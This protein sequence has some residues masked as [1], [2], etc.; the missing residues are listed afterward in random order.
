MQLAGKVVHDR[1]F[2]RQHQQNIRCAEQI[3]FLVVLFQ[4]QLMFNVAHRVVAEI[5][6]QPTRESQC[7]I[8]RR[9]VETL[10]IFFDERQRVLDENMLQRL[11]LAAHLRPHNRAFLALHPQPLMRRQADNRVAAKSLTANDGFEQV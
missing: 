4:F 7:T 10:P 9:G 2:V 3:L 11:G 6:R 8:D 5:T 1:K